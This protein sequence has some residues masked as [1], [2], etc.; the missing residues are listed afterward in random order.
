MAKVVMFRITI[1]LDDLEGRDLMDQAM[2]RLWETSLDIEKDCRIFCGFLKEWLDVSK[3]G[4]PH[5]QRL[6]KT[7][8]GFCDEF[9]QKPA[10]FVDT[11]MAGYAM[12]DKEHAI[13]VRVALEA[14]KSRGRPELGKHGGERWEMARTE[15]GSKLAKKEGEPQGYV[16]TLPL[17]KV[18]DEP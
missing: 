1:P 16:M 8:S 18:R 12:L 3:E 4:V 14:A 13:P 10:D 9:I 11:L 5:W 2:M 7:W 15:D 6:S 17:F